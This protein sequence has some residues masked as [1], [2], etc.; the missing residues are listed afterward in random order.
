MTFNRDI[1]RNLLKFIEDNLKFV[2]S[3]GMAPTDFN[4]SGVYLKDFIETYPNY[5]VEDVKYAFYLI[6]YAGY[7]V[8]NSDQSSE[9]P[10]ITGFTEKGIAMLLSD[11]HK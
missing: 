2:N 7:F 9:S 1:I 5:K 3:D 4:I 11:L 8:I 6:K 10:C